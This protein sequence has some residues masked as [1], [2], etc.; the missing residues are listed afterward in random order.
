MYIE[1]LDVSP[2]TV[3]MIV[4]GIGIVKMV[5][6]YYDYLKNKKH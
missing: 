3:I 4:L 1:T 6:Y 2:A 5:G